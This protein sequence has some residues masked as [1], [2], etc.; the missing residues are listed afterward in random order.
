MHET[1]VVK[2]GHTQED[3][4]AWMAALQDRMELEEGERYTLRKGLLHPI[5]RRDD[6]PGLRRI[7]IME[8]ADDAAQEMARRLRR[9]MR[10]Y[11][12][13]PARVISA[14]VMDAARQE[15]SV[16]DALVRTDLQRWFQA[17]DPANPDEGRVTSSP[18]EAATPPLQANAQVNAPNARRG[19]T[20]L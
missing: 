2:A 6:D 12:P 18:V 16:M 7:R 13:D 1:V 11:R 10:G 15:P 20:A 9:G 19:A 5:A 14:V 3:I 17:T 4:R 8:E